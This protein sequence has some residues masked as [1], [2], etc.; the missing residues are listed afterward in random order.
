MVLP[1]SAFSVGRDRSTASPSLDYCLLDV[2]VDAP[3]YS[4][5]LG[6]YLLSFFFFFFFFVL[7]VVVVIIII[8]LLL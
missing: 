4:S 5:F 3:S 8:L 6:F 2:D 7:L 1:Q